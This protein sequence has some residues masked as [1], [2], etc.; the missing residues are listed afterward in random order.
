M[1]EVLANVTDATMPVAL[2][3]AELPLTVR[4]Y[5]ES[6]PIASNDSE[7]G[8]EENRRIEFR[9]LSDHPVRGAPLA[10]PVTMPPH[11][12]RARRS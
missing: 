11:P 12:P 4:G 3:L 2:E 5:G 9:L 1:R 10:P 6:Q 7:E 8:R